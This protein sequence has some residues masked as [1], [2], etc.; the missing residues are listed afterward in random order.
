[1]AILITG[2]AGYI[3]SVTVD[4]LRRGGE[5][6][7]VLDDLF[8]GHREAL[9]PEIPF[10]EGKIGD[11]GLVE[12]IV[13]RHSVDEC[14]HF[15][16]LAYVGESMSQPAWY[17]ENNVEQ[18]VR[19]L[20]CLAETG[21][22][23]FVFSSSCAT[24][25]MPRQLPIPEEHP[26]LPVNPYGWSKFLIEQVLEKYGGSHGLRFVALR[27]FNAAGAT[28]THGEHHDPETHLIPN[29]LAVARGRLPFV[30]IFGATYPT[31]DG[32][33]VRDYIHVADLASAHR[34][35]LDYLRSGG[36]SSAFNL[37]NERGY[38]VLELVET[39][40][41][42]TGRPIECRL[43]RP[44]PGDPPELVGCAAKARRRL[45]W[46][47][48]HTDLATIIRTAWQWHCRN[49]HGYST[50]PNQEE[51]RTILKENR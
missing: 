18:G 8:R 25:G 45:G 29:V 9:H 13:R 40:R 1:M 43:E 22:A 4:L 50:T 21:V 24:Y 6:V 14:I 36:T 15:A 19:L 27:Y 26:Q 12:R 33:A 2:G 31:R 34:C 23:R 51:P 30:R 46:Q 37:G 3:G 32:T 38:S 10:Y 41:T 42:V 16:A 5:D 48:V 39:A 47:P 44:R 35:A 49:P 20:H 28:E 17:Y 7:V 11:A